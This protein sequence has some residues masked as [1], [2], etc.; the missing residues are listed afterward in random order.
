[1]PGRRDR[2][3]AGCHRPPAGATGVRRIRPAYRHPAGTTGVQRGATGVPAG[4][5]RPP[6]GTTGIPASGGYDRHT[7]R[8]QAPTITRLSPDR[9]LDPSALVDFYQPPRARWLRANFVTSLDGAVEVG[10]VSGQLSSPA[11]QLL[12]H[13]LRMQCHAL[14]VGAGTLRREGYGPIRLDE[15]SRAWRRAHGLAPD[16]VLALVSRRLDLDPGHAMFTEA[17]ARPIVF[18]CEAAPAE[19]RAAL[20]ATAEVVVVG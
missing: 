6:A 14:L 10:G 2:R 19:R 16:P 13:T 4:C 3:P 20:A 5:D 9:R 17:P 11:D 7:F 18:T 8:V 15:S 12:L 1:E